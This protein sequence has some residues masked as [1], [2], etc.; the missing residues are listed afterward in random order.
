MI[1]T[2]VAQPI[3]AASIEE[4]NPDSAVSWGAVV[5]GA[6]AA[7][8]ITLI[9][10]ALGTGLGLTSISPWP[11]ASASATAL[12]VGAVIWLVVMQWLSAAVGG[13]LAG[14]LRTQAALATGEVQ[15]RDTAHGLLAWAL[16]TLLVVGVLSTTMAAGTVGTA[17]AGSGGSPTGAA[18]PASAS[19]TPSNSIVAVNP[20]EYRV[21]AL[22]RPTAPN[23][24]A[25]G[26]P[27][28]A[29][30]RAEALR[31]LATGI[32]NGDVSPADRTYLADLVAAR[33]GMG[34]PDAEKRV[35]AV[36]A[37]TKDDARKAAEIADKARK[38][39]AAL[40][41]L[42]AL[43]LVIGAFIGCVAGGYG[44][45]HRDELA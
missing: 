44:G 36:I 16:A 2:T 32:S 42:I 40:S 24:V 4:E 5:G 35:D 6:V 9:I 31:I 21:D 1:D 38:A 41:I 7:A 45:H 11:G 23:A 27:P 37:G 29:E 17:A 8:A 28:L 14:R 3:V 39:S 43:S 26:S 33:S 18:A 12:T 15:F 19:G 10:F 25:G 30:S 13:Y 22:F 34:R 20:L